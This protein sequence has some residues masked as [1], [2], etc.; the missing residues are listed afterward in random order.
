[1]KWSVY[2]DRVE[3]KMEEHP[4]KAVELISLVLATM[5]RDEDT[6]DLDVDKTWSPD[7]IEEINGHLEYFGLLPDQVLMHEKGE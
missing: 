6:M 7:T 4:D 2:A 5:Y 3:K 1:M